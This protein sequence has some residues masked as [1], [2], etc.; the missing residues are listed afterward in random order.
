MDL[1][2]RKV[3]GADIIPSVDRGLMLRAASHLWSQIIALLGL[4]CIRLSL[5]HLLLELAE[6]RAL[7]V[8][9][10]RERLEHWNEAGFPKQP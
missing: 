4:A 2:L 6:G 8:R 5:A 10:L 1:V 7:T 9:L 3:S